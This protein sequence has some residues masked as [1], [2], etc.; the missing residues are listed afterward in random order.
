MS[1]KLVFKVPCPKNARAPPCEPQIF[2][3]FK[4]NLYIRKF[5]IGG[6]Y[7]EGKGIS[8]Y[9]SLKLYL[10]CNPVDE[11]LTDWKCT[12]QCQI[13]FDES[14]YKET[15]NP[16]P[17]VLKTLRQ[18]QLL[19]YKSLTFS[20][21]NKCLYVNDFFFEEMYEGGRWDSP[22]CGISRCFCI[23]CFHVFEVT[24]KNVVINQ[25]SLV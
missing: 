15:F 12:T 7:S 9:Y 8:N 5:P 1:S 19:P 22:I 16:V 20:V 18:N 4:W 13:I 21:Q 11:D 14:I 17:N 24:F 25:P 3:G 2:G 10:E 23:E 6:S